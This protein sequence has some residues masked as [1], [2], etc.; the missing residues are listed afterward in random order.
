VFEV[1]HAQASDVLQELEVVK[2]EISLK[3]GTAT[4]E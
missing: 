3:E 4:I 2:V 1:W